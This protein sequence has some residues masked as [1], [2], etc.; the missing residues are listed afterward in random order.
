MYELIEGFI[1]IEVVVDDF[2]VVDF[3][4]IYEEVVC[5][6]NRNFVVFF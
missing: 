6:R 3:G 5:D 4:D 1:G 2:M